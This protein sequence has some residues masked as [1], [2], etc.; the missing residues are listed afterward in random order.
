MNAEPVVG[1]VLST[2]FEEAMVW[3]NELF[4]ATPRKG[5]SIPYMTHLL[6][7]AALVL[8]DGGT[9]DEAI[10][11]LLHDVLEDIGM[12]SRAE[13]RDRFGVGVE[14]IV[15]GCTDADRQLNED[16][17]TRK[18]KAVAH[19]SDA[20]PEVVRVSLADKLHN[21]RSILR[22]VA[23]IGDAVWERFNVGRDKQLEYYGLL[24]EAFR[25][26]RHGWMVD[27]LA[28]TVERISRIVGANERPSES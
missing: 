26:R 25:K 7:V 11:G 3:A 4:R 8:E 28:R 5:T 20:S 10:A 21:A 14:D 17:W 24:V 27:E 19:L 15:I 6:S 12:D 9:E 18:M 23:Q 22:E 2:R 1:P 16:S 13:I